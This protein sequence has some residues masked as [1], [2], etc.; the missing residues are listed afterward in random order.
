ME[1]SIVE[2][3]KDSD[4]SNSN[5]EIKKPAYIGFA[6]DPEGSDKWKNFEK[7]WSEEDKANLESILKKVTRNVDKGKNLNTILTKPEMAWTAGFVWRATLWDFN[8][9]AID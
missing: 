5:L 7:L 3:N 2:L 4:K 6:P 9:R 8:W 1:E